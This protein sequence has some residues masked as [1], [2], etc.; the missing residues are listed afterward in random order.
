MSE[1]T[2]GEFDPNLFVTNRAYSDLFAYV[3]NRVSSSLA[4]DTSQKVDRF[5]EEF[6]NTVLN[7]R[8]S[9]AHVFTYYAPLPAD[10]AVVSAGNTGVELDQSRFSYSHILAHFVRAAHALIPKCNI[11]L[12]TSGEAEVGDGLK[13]AQIVRLKVDSYSPMLERAYAMNAY[14]KSSLFTANTLFLDSDAIINGNIQDIFDRKFDVG[15]TFRED[16]HLMPINEGVL[17]ASA[18]NKSAVH[19]FF[20][21]YLGTYTNLL[22]DLKIAERFGSEFSNLKKW[23]GGQLSLNAVVADQLARRRNSESGGQRGRSN[24]EFFHCDRYNFTPG[25]RAYSDSELSEKKII[26]LKGN[27]KEHLNVI[28]KLQTR[29]GRVK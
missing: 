4:I 9:G 18:R 27:L 19:D 20:D 29:L 3:E 28:V 17:L 16:S 14:V 15:L 1:G 21:R 10:S 22:E 11:I 2:A 24:L 26:H 6:E 25:A 7:F 12:V 5:R 23:R 8:S 13:G